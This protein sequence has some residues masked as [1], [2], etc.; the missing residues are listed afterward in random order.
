MRL[1]PAE[2]KE[3]KCSCCMVGGVCRG[4]HEANREEEEEEEEG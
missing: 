3:R 2:S 1:R 4:L